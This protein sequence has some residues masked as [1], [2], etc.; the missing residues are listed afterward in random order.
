[1]AN[2]YVNKVVFGGVAIVDITP[3]TAAESDVA[4]GKVFF[5]ADGS[6]ATGTK[7]DSGGGGGLVYEEGTYEPTADASSPS[8]SFA[9]AHSGR[10][11]FVCIYDT[12]GDVM[13]SNSIIY[14]EFISTFDLYGYIPIAANSYIYG[15]IK[16][17][18]K[19]TT[20]SV[21]NSLYA[22]EAAIN[23]IITSSGFKASSSSYYFRANRTYKWIAVWKPTV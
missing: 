13:A 15:T 14:W 19:T 17:Y 7:T 21:T 12:T 16:Y 23:S 10:P 8:I 6:M 3:T 4:S 20:T 1:M 22:N 11:F 5:K 18:R 9:N 2:Q